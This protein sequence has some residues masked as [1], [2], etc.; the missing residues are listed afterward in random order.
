MRAAC[1]IGLFSTG[2]WTACLA[3]EAPAWM[4]SDVYGRYGQE[5]RVLKP[6]APV[7]VSGRRVSVWGRDMAWRAESLLPA[8]VASGGVELLARPMHLVVTLA[9]RDCVVPLSRF[10]VLAG[11]CSGVVVSLPCLP[12]TTTTHLS[13]TSAGPAAA[14]PALPGCVNDP[15]THPPCRCG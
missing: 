13:S 6:W 1:L 10:E 12:T 2:I 5:D 11:C 4:T 9:G 3:Q 15:T 7:R 14:G 8:S